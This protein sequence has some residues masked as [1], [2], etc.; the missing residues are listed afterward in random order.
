MFRALQRSDFHLLRQW[1][2]EP[3][4]H[5][6]WKQSLDL[7]GLERKYG[8]RID[9][10]D[11]THVFVMSADE[12]LVGFIQWYRWSD[13]PAH[14]M[15]LGV[16]P[17]AAGMDLAIGDPDMIGRGLGPV[18]IRSFLRDV[19]FRVPEIE[20]VVTDIDE[21]NLRSLR[22]FAKVEFIAQRTVQLLGEDCKR[23]VLRVPRFKG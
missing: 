7:E 14:A 12:R 22:A 9:G 20:S 6:W 19:V 23:K 10:S 18:F 11:P 5:R 1:L 3:H 8:P 15:Q 4:V 2:A 17:L 21:R 16:E 13:Y